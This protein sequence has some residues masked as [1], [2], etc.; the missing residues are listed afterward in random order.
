SEERLFAEDELRV[1]EV[2]QGI[3]GS[4]WYSTDEGHL[5]RIRKI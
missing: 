5:F 3:D 2:E 1:R 4:V